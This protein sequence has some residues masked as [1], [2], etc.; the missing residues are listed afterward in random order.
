MADPLL[1]AAASARKRVEAGFLTVPEDGEVAFRSLFTGTDV[2]PI[3]AQAYVFV[4][5]EQIERALD[6]G[7]PRHRAL[8]GG[9]IEPLLAGLLVKDDG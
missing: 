2:D 1:V 5:A 4:L 7:L 3:S 8:L 6:A 9:L